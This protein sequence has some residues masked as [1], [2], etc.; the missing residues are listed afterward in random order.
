[1]TITDTPGATA[2]TE[3]D[4]EAQVGA[5][6]QRLF[7]TGLAALEAVTISLG[8]ELGLY[9]HLAGPPVTFAELAAASGIDARYA[10]E[11]CE[12]QATAGLIHVD[13]PDAPAGARRFSLPVAGQACLLDPESPAS[14]GPLID[15]VPSVARV[16]PHA[17]VAAYRTGTGIPYADYVLHDIQGD[18]NRPAFVHQLVDEWLPAIPGLTTRLSAGP[19][20]AAEIGCGEGWAAIS[21]ALALPDLIVDAFDTDEAS[22]AAARR[23]A[24]DAGLTDRVHFEVVDVT[25]PLPEQIVEGTYDLVMAFEMVHDLARPVDALATMLRLG[26]PGAVHLVMDERAAEAFQAPTE[27]P[28]E[29]LLYAASVLHCLPV[30]RADAPTSAATGT[31]MRP[32]TLERYARAA[33]FERVDILPI[34]NDMFRFYHLIP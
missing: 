26:A 24:T 18:F 12:Q 34:E 5:Y 31:V 7:E 13:H 20:R 30:G 15:L 4:L 33:G 14:V 1:M 3:T 22:I 25:K 8:R 27:D 11:W 17:L 28:I 16:Y 23:H 21:L 29:R 19:A 9:D 10:Q 6:A 2:D 32:S